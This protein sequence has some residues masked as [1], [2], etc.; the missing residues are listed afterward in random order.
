MADWRPNR[1]ADGAVRQRA[2]FLDRDGVLIR[3]TVRDGKPYAIAPLED[4]VILDGVQDACAELSRAGLLLIVV[5]NQPDV[6]RGTTLRSFVEETNRY[7]IRA[8][9]LYDARVC[10]HDDGDGCDCRKPKPGLI[11]GAAEEF[12]IDLAQST[13]VGD[14]WRDIEAGRRAGCHTVLIGD[15][16]AEPPSEPPDHTAAS[17]A[18]AV[19]WICSSLAT[20]ERS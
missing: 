9:G 8:L 6:A 11:T 17:L 5:T 16:Y 10:Y 4:A 18:D 2:V 20:A 12:G 3:T 15:G 1:A 14:R 13:M 7:L 19:P